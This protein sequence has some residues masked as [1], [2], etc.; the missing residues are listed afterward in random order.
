MK[1]YLIPMMM[2]LMVL[3][4][5]F[6]VMAEEEATV[7]VEAEEVVVDEAKVK[8]FVPHFNPAMAEKVI[9]HFMEKYDLSEDDSIGDL[10]DAIQ[11]DME[12]K[13][14]NLMEELGVDTDEE[15]KAALKDEHIDHLREVLE[16]DD[17]LSDE[18][19]LEIAK[20]E[21]EDLVI[22]LLGLDADAS[23][24]EIE[25]ALKEWRKENRVLMQPFRAPM[26][27]IRGLF[28]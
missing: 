21:R 11:E 12:E 15:L 1:K 5:A 7:S 19:V 18:E 23:E 2:V 10:L 6:V 9:T 26:K 22:E 3:S 4:S 28:N 24:E 17:D 20:E 25:E 13:K 16:L 8:P 27:F 14:D